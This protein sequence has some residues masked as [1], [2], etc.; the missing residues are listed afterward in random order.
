MA[1]SSPPGTSGQEQG[2]S[3]SKRTDSRDES[4]DRTGKAEEAGEARWGTM[5]RGGLDPHPSE[6]TGSRPRRQ[7][8]ERPR[9]TGMQTHQRCDESDQTLP[10]AIGSSSRDPEVEARLAKLRFQREQRQYNKMVRV[11]GHELGASRRRR[12][13]DPHEFEGNAGLV[14]YKE[15]IGFGMSVITLMATLFVV[16]YVA[17]RHLTNDAALVRF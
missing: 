10:E 17:A 12:R 7:A 6:T 9:E 4:D 5:W 13:Y 16:G 3:G 11:P 15:Q 14:S 2:A 1:S 8:V